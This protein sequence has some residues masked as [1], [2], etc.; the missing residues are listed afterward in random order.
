MNTVI[1]DVGNVLVGYD[2]QSYLRTFQY[3]EEIYERVADA[4]FRN[5]DWLE[6]DIGR[7]S[8]EEWLKLFIEN[9][10]EVEPQIREVFEGFEGTIVP[11]S[12]TADWIAYFRSQGY[13]LYYLSNYS[14]ELY[15]KSKDKLSF[16]DSFDGGIF[17]YQ[18]KCIKPDEKI[19]KILMERYSIR[20]CDAT[21]YDDRPE[22]VEAAVRLGMKGVVFHQDIPL[23]LMKK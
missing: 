17:S 4:V 21:F 18:V 23:Q 14:K 1:F 8:T 10:P 12:Y 6:G 9:A 13:K 16:L 2:W 15:E 5:E 11:L 7:V 20:P 3:S 22:N 19:Y